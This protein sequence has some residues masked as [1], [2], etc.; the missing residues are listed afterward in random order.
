[1]ESDHEEAE[2]RLLLHAHH[3]S[4]DYPQ[5]IVQS[6]DTD[7]AVICVHK[8]SVMT[9]QKLG[10]LTGV[11]NR[12]RYIPI[13]DIV[14]AIGPDICKVLP[15]LHALTGCYSTSTLRGIGK[16]TSF[17]KLLRAKDHQTNI[18]QLEDVIPPTESTIH[19]CEQF[20]CSLY[21]TSNTAGKTAD[22]V[23]YWM[24]CQKRPK[25]ECLPPTSDSRCLHINQANY[26]AF[27]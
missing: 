21:T 18:S 27:I 23:R 2:T 22:E 16:K 19:A 5:V 1:M 17:R 14:S 26:Q 24:F 3:V 6:P 20:V 15:A 12:R 25:T 8:Y 9:C 11:N 7:V 4:T 10:F 13:H